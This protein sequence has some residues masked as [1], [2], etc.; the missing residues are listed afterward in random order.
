[1]EVDQVARVD[2]VLELGEVTQTVD[3]MAEAPL[4]QS[5]TTSLGQVVDTKKVVDLPL[6]GRNFIQLIALAAGAYTPQRNNSLYQNFLIGINGNRI[7]NN[8]FLLDGVNNNTTDNNNAPVLPSPDA[9]AEFKVQ[10]NLLPAEY[11]RGLGGTIN[12]NLKSGTNEFH[13]TA[14]EFLRNSTLDANAYFNSG[15]AKPPFQQNQFGFAT[16]GPVRLPKL[17]DGHDRTFFFGDYQG[18]R[19][20]KGLTRIFTVPT[21]AVRAGDFSGGA[22]IYD[23]ETTRLNPQ[24]GSVRDPFPDNRIP[25]QRMDPIMQRYLSLYPLPNRPGTANN[26]VLNPKFSDNNDQG[27]IKVD[28]SF[29]A[30]DSIFARYSMGN[31]TFVVP[32]NVQGVPFNG[33]FSAI[34]F[35]PQVINV[36]GVALG[37]THTFSPRMINE[38]R[39]GYNRLFAT[40]T[41]RSGGRNLS[42]EFGIPG[43]PDDKQANGLATVGITGFSGLG[44]SFDTRRGQNVYQ[45][46]DNV[47]VLR[48]R[49]S[50]KMGFD[51][52]RTGFNL[53]QGSSPRGNFSYDGVFSRNP[54]SPV[55]TGNAFADFLLGYPSSASIGNLVHMGIRI[56][57]YSAFFQDDWKVTT[58]LVMNVG[59]RYEYTTPVTEVANRMAN[60]D[61]TTNN[62]IVARKGS[63]RD[64]ALANP[65][66]NN[67]GPRF[68]LAYQLTPNTVVRTGYGIF[69][70]LED[71]GHHNPTFN[72]PFQVNLSFPSDQVNPSTARRP[73]QGFPVITLGNDFRNFFL[74]VNGRPFDFPAAYSQQWNLTV[75]RQI[76]AVL[77]QAAYVG[78]KA[79]KLMANRNINQPTPGS[80]SVN[81]RR[82]FPGWGSINF[83]EPR[84]NS[85]YHGL[86]MKAEQRFSQGLTFLVSYTFAKA[87][88]DSDSTQLSTAAGTG[89]AQDQRNLRAERSRSF[90]DVRHR[91]VVSYVYELPFGAGKP[92][93]SGLGDGWDRLLGGW[94]I[95]GITMLQSGRAFTV[96]SPFDHSNTGS[97]NIRPDATGIRPE[98][99]GSERSVG[100]FFNPAAY[101]LP[102]GFAFGNA[103]RNTGTG[104]RQVNFDFA[105][106][107]NIP[108]ASDSKRILQFRAEFFN[109]M[110]T[111]QFQIPNRIF[112]TPQFATI[113]ETIN[114]NRDIQLG[115]KFIW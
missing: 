108:L 98:L 21:P 46:L 15:R 23:P 59:L 19:I 40:V 14:F 56:R 91:L 32:L 86:Q 13:G 17:Y 81:A 50:F 90:Q 6:N 57:N 92:W 62:V 11:G 84:G 44:D 29:S 77:V 85:I 43:V 33:Y 16:G 71:A 48:G 10:S 101:A 52:R 111:P 54:L 26:F 61:P 60:F 89:N 109:I 106:F 112:G 74:N 53:N 28:H 30:N 63:L 80:G 12:V 25:A 1:L 9:I 42:T 93:L 114:D 5:E 104:P 64:R 34:E 95:N 66:R 68:G 96:N 70:T 97:A 35:E 73:S 37:Y 99:P 51:H 22:T 31:E 79:N 7:Q 69:Y 87:L 110:N 38:I 94:Q 75:E 100:R 115:L 4:L 47:T 76:G 113:T 65:D 55:G 24:G 107:K 105:V 78:N 41:P 45:V 18:T 8:N 39:L 102:T 82:P 36:R 72:P 67:F 49:H 2:F 83:Q 103:G 20:R 58:R 3:V 88:D 27:D